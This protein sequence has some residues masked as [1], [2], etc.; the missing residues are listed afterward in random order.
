MTPAASAPASSA[1][2]LDGAK[3]VALRAAPGRVVEAKQDDEPTGLVYDL[4]VLH[5]DGTTTDVEVDATTGHVV[6]L[7]SDTD[8]WDGS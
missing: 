6:S 2:T 8:Q 5:Q 1:L 3:A 4:T 7:K